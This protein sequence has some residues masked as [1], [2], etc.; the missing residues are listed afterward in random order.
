MSGAARTVWAEMGR[1]GAVRRQAGTEPLFEARQC[2]GGDSK[3]WATTLLLRRGAGRGGAG[4][5]C[6]GRA[7]WAMWAWAREA[8]GT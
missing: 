6:R 2:R 8:G 4:R 5:G 1:G 7:A 3:H